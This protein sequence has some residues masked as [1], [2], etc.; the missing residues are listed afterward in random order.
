MNNQTW[1]EIKNWMAGF[2][3]RQ[4]VFALITMVSLLLFVGLTLLAGRMK[5]WPADQRAA[6]RWSKA[7]DYGQVSCFFAESA[8]IDRYQVMSF[9]NQIETGL[10]EASYENKEGSGRIYIDAYSSQGKITIESGKSKLETR[11]VGIGGDFFQFHP[12]QL[13]TGGYF[14]GNDLMQDHI[15]IDEYAAWQLFGSNDVIGMQVLIGK[16]PHFIS[17]VITRAEGRMWEGAGLEEG[18]VF[19]SCETLETYGKT[20][21]INSY[22]A[23][24]PNPV[25]GFAYQLVKEKFGFD[26]LEMEVIDN[27]NRYTIEPLLSTI[28]DFGLRSMQHYAIRYP[29]WENYARGYEDFLAVILILQAVFFLTAAVILTAALIKGY[30]HRRWT[31]KGVGKGLW[32]FVGMTGSRIRQGMRKEKNRWKFF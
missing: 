28:M 5:Q 1:R 26:E 12:M 21:G 6:Q 22:E 10:K 29:Y 25:S 32:N 27:T 16:V 2:S 3:V 31:W 17:G 7:G 4:I 15:V 8:K 13:V 23:V 11:A 20:P 30:R 24:M 18:V 14:S 19:L 9:R